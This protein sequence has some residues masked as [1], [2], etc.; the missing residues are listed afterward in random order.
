MNVRLL[1]KVVL[2][3]LMVGC[4]FYSVSSYNYAYVQLP[5]TLPITDDKDALLGF[6]CEVM[7]DSNFIAITE[8]EEKEVVFTV[9]NNYSNP[10]TVNVYII[11][12]SDCSITLDQ[13]TFYLLAGDSKDVCMTV[14]PQKD[15]T[16][17]ITI[18]VI[19]RSKF[20]SSTFKR[21]FHFGE[22][23]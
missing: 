3:L 23:E 2:F 19:S 13:D 21:T 5:V 4:L 15:T 17:D 7:E 20:G 14:T 16:F 1:V 9:R 11:S 22:S 18:K 10:V 6:E 8:G 12:D